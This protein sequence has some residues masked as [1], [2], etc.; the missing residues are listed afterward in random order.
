MERYFHDYGLKELTL[1]K[2]AYYLKQCTDS[3]QSL[4][5]SQW[6]FHRNRTKIPR[7]IWNHKRLQIDKAILRKK[8]K[9]GDIIS[10]TS[11]YI[12]STI[13][14]EEWYWQKNNHTDQWYRI[15]SPEINL[16]ENGELIF[17]KG[18]RNI[19]WKVYNK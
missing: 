10:L 9:A 1:L 2:C 3:V 11:N 18:A 4:S 7:F 17:D 5:K 8:N 14:K 12:Q 6:L 16:H 13:I 19:Q 15:E